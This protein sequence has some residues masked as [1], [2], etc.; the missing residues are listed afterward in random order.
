MKQTIIHTTKNLAKVG[1]AGGVIFAIGFAFVTQDPKVEEVGPA[2]AQADI[3]DFI[4]APASKSAKFTEAMVGLGLTPRTY[5]FNGNVM[6]F[7]VGTSHK[8]VK[9]MEMMDKIQEHLVDYG[10]NKKNHSDMVPMQQQA[11]KINWDEASQSDEK[12]HAAFEPLAK[13]ADPLLDDGDIV[14]VHV[15]EHY[16]EMVGVDT[17]RDL[18]DPAA[19]AEDE[20]NRKVRNLMGGYK[21]IDATWDGDRTEITAVWTAEDFSAERHEGEGLGQSPP[22][23]DVPTC[24]GCVRDYR[25]Q[26]IDKSDAFQANM[27]ATNVDVEQTYQFY[28]RAMVDRGWY[29]TG[30]QPMMDRLAE[31]M[32]EL[33]EVQHQGRILNLERDGQAMQLA[34][35]PDAEAGT[36]VLTL[37]ETS[38]AQLAH[39]EKVK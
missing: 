23:P 25:M 14:P 12:M 20:S 37:H 7:A 33:R 15:S 5:D 28:K 31:Y 38:G 35:I 36:R 10:V 29:E 19:L 6:Y 11:R 26:T 30:A 27:F 24:M 17:N 8:G 21:Y 34:I 39:P 2:K 22:D 13:A 32:P 9:P 1:A 18:K 16:V 4:G 3:Q